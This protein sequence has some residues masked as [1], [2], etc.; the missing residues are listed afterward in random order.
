M[1][2]HIRQ[3]VALVWLLFLAACLLP[4]DSGVW[5]TYRGHPEAVT[6]V[7]P[8]IYRVWYEEAA[9]CLGVPAD[10]YDNIQWLV[11]MGSSWVNAEYGPNWR[12]IGEWNPEGPRIWL[13]SAGLFDEWLVKHELMHDLTHGVLGHP[14]PP[15]DYCEHE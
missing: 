15:F 11:V 13:V 12:Q 8:P 10:N 9:A 1:L 5:W 3:R 14:S 6:L 4:P 2:K 7:P